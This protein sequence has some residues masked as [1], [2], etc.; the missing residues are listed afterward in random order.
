MRCATFKYD[1]PT[2]KV[3]VAKVDWDLYHLLGEVKYELNK[4]GTN[5]NQLAHDARATA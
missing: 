3:Q 2:S 5:I 1:L 4:I